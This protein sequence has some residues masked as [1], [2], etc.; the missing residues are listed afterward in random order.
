MSEKEPS[1]ESHSEEL[2]NIYSED[3]KER[4]AIDDLKPEER[5]DALQKVVKNDV[6]RIERV[7]EIV[8]NREL[9]EPADF[10]HAA[11]VFQHSG[12]IEDYALAHLLALR[13]GEMGYQQQE[14]EVDP[15]WL[16]AAAKDRWLVSIGQLQDYGTQYVGNKETGEMTRRPVNPNITDEERKKW[17]VKPLGE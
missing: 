10:L 1:A 3:Q 15:L 6:V 5:Y 17:H 11:M 14:K 4:A 12:K 7:R 2:K 13:A 8:L 9:K 16:A